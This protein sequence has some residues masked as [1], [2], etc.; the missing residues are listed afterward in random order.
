MK[1]A[2]PL[3]VDVFYTN[4][5][6]QA[7]E[8]LGISVPIEH[9]DLRPMTFYE[10]N[11]TSTFIEENKTYAR[12]HSNGQYFITNLTPEKLDLLIFNLSE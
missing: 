10:I 7:I 11:C 1:L 4:D 12:I 5:E 9:N 6:T 2:R 3:K 8:D